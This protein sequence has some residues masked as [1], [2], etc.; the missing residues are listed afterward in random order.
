LRLRSAATDCTVAIYTVNPLTGLAFDGG[1]DTPPRWTSLEPY[2][3]TFAAAGFT[4]FRWGAEQ[5]KLRPLRP[6]RPR[7]Q[8]VLAAG[9]GRQ[10]LAV[11]PFTT[12]VALTISS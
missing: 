8:H 5:L 7:R 6:H 4:L 10:T 3:T 2:L 1:Q 9:P 11:P 12:D